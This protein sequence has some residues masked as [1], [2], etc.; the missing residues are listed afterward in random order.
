MALYH[1]KEF[2]FEHVEK[3]EMEGVQRL[4]RRETEVVE[5]KEL[6]SGSR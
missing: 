5:E 4:R 6:Q 3:R 1:C 2:E